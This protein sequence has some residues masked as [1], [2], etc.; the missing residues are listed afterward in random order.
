MYREKD[1][2]L[3]LPS[4]AQV[5]VYL[6][7]PLISFLKQSDFVGS[8]R[9]ENGVRIWEP[10]W[11]HRHPAVPCFTAPVQPHGSLA[12]ARG[13]LDYRRHY[14]GDVFLGGAPAKLRKQG[15]PNWRK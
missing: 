5:F 10:L 15:T 11:E 9:L 13:D 8:F 2:L 6:F 7:A 12:R 14:Y 1:L 4:S 3:C